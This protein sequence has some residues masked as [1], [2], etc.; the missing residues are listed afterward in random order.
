MR[1]ETTRK[2]HHCC[3]FHAVLVVDDMLCVCRE[4]WWDPLE[5]RDSEKAVA[6]V[7]YECASLAP[8][9]LRARALLDAVHI[10]R[11][12]HTIL[13]VVVRAGRIEIEKL[14]G[15]DAIINLAG[16]SVPLLIRCP[17]RFR[18]DLIPVQ[19]KTSGLAVGTP[20]RSLQS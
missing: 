3:I 4:I 6:A 2:P 1:Q 18:T 19:V 8:Q 12:M 7:A 15:F 14:E 16:V 17:A 20:T 9:C 13:Y 10:L 5:G 11:C